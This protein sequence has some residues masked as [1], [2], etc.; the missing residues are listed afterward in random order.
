MSETKIDFSTF[1][2]SM[3]SSAYCSLGLAPN[4]LSQKVEKNLIV[5]KQQIDLLEILKEKTKGNL[6]KDETD[7]MENILYHL[8]M[9]YVNEVKRDEEKKS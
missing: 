3:A 8:H 6:T 1:L 9:T 7:L 2:M 5:A 4:P